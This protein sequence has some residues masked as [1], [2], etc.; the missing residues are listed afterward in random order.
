MVKIFFNGL[1]SSADQNKIIIHLF[2]TPK[3]AASI[4]AAFLGVVFY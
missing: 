2:L 4:E 3:K 1:F